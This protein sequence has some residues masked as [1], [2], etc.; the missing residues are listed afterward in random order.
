M[1]SNP[2]VLLLPQVKM[3]SKTNPCHF[4]KLAQ[5]QYQTLLL[6]GNMTLSLKPMSVAYSTAPLLTL[7]RL[8]A[9]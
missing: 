8:T 1:L 2:P 4:H 7:A 3:A 5:N 9:S 6:S